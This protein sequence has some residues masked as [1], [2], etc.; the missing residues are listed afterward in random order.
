MHNI[1]KLHD[2]GTVIADGDF[3]L[4]QRVPALLQNL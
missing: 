3:A 2:G 1:K 4:Q